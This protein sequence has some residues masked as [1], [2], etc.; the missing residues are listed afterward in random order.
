MFKT[1]AA[2]LTVS[3][4]EHIHRKKNAKLKI[5]LAFPQCTNNRYIELLF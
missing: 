4:Q 2:T 1:I 3:I 5:L